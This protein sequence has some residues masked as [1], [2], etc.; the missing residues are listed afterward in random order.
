MAETPER[1]ILVGLQGQEWEADIVSRECLPCDL[2]VE[3]TG[4]TS[5]PGFNRRATIC[6]KQ[7][8]EVR[9]GEG[10]RPAEHEFEPYPEVTSSDRCPI[11]SG[12]GDRPA[13]HHCDE[14]GHVGPATAWWADGTA[15]C[16]RCAY[17]RPRSGEA[18]RV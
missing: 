7:L 13:E 10:D 6:T 1:V 16:A 14:C 2:I 17:V 15:E 12:E 8:R 5:Y 11:H 9:C 4:R 18:D 3:F